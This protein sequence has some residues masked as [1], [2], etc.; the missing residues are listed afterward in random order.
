[1]DIL[2]KRKKDR[3]LVNDDAKF[4]LHFKGN[5]RRIKLIR[6]RLDELADA[7]CLDV[8]R[9]LPMAGCHELKG[10]RAGQL[11]VRL[12]KGFRMVFE[13]ANNPIPEKPDG[14]LDWHRVTAIR[15]VR[16]AE[17]YHD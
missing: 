4:R 2:F 6:A 14:G 8:M 11:A 10:N 9:T 17:D 12:D 5:P 16:L 15:I 13:T 7:E 3:S 1:M